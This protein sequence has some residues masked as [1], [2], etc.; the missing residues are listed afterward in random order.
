VPANPPA[1]HFW[2]ITL[3]D[4]NTRCLIQNK[5]QLADRSSRQADLLKNADGS[6]DL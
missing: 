3:Y 5:E 2:S 1:T 4:L 6:V